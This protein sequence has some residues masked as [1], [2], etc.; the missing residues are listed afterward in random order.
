MPAPI[1][2]TKRIPPLGAMNLVSATSQTSASVASNP[3]REF[4]SLAGNL[5]ESR[6]HMEANY[7]CQEVKTITRI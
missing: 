4:P 7:E 5:N 1:L 3:Q 6:T 2:R